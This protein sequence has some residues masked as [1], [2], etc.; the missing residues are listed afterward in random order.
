MQQQQHSE[1]VRKRQT[2]LQ[3][4]S[5]C[6]QAMPPRAGQPGR[7]GRL[8]PGDG[9]GPFCLASK[10][11]PGL[12]RPEKTEKNESSTIRFLH[13]QARQD[14]GSG[15]DATEIRPG[16]KSETRPYRRLSRAQLC[17]GPDPRDVTGLTGSLSRKAP[18]TENNHNNSE[19]SLRGFLAIFPGY[20][21]TRNCVCFVSVRTFF[22]GIK[23]YPRGNIGLG[24]ESA[25]PEF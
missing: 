5:S 24:K 8:Q 12:S 11:R 22:E 2:H 10:S 4:C 7:S 13:L 16:R 17:A 1:A 20:R 6:R 15:T 21:V 19:C 23:D 3:N 9:P 25:N 14:G 18:F